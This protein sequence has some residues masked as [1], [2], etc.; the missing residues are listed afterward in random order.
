MLNIWGMVER[1]SKGSLN[2]KKLKSFKTYLDH[3]LALGP[4][5]PLQKLVG[6]KLVLQRQSP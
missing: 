4:A 6:G 5:R 3:S 2:V 1:R